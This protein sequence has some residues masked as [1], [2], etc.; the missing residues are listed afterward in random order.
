[1]LILIARSRLMT[2]MTR[3]VYKYSGVVLLYLT[4]HLQDTFRYSSDSPAAE[5]W[6]WGDKG[7]VLPGLYNTRTTAY[8][9][10]AVSRVLYRWCSGQ[11]TSLR[12]KDVADQW[13]LRLSFCLHRLDRLCQHLDG[14]ITSEFWAIVRSLCYI[15]Q[16]NGLLLWL[17]RVNMLG[18]TLCLPSEHISK[19]R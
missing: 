7:V 8:W 9:Q 11:Q 3:C 14:K 1:M 16:A 19:N 13:W 12:R 18:Q 5:A 15:G 6:W 10:Y 2:L 17:V 4:I